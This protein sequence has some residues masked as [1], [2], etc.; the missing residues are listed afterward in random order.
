MQREQRL[1]LLHEQAVKKSKEL[2]KRLELNLGA[3]NSQRGELLTIVEDLAK[4][5]KE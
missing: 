5:L 3:Q 4:Q 2:D 1:E